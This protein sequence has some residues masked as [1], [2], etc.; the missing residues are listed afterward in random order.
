MFSSHILKYPE[1]AAMDTITPGIHLNTSATIVSAGEMF[2]LGFY[3][4]ANSMS[5]YMAI[6][7]KNILEDR[8]V[9]IANRDY[10]VTASALFCI[11][12]HGNL[13]IRQGG[14]IYMVTDLQL[15]N[16]NVSAT[17]L[18]SGNLVFRDENSSILWQS[19]D[20]PAHTFLPRMKLGYGR[21]IGKTWLYV[22]WRS[23]NDPSPGN[24][25]LQLDPGKRSR[26]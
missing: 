13:A 24:F 8:V 19:F 16:A 6:M 17:L 10:P 25:T 1:A 11:G 20:F 12:N 7:Y 18:D 22:S 4:P 2:E 21:R 26:L 14:I 5:Y 9:W 3:Q 15:T 23:S